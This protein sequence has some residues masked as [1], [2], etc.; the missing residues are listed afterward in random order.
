MHRT[1]I[2]ATLSF[3]QSGDYSHRSCSLFAFILQKET[4]SMSLKGKKIYSILH[5]KCPRC[6]EGELFTN[7]AYSKSFVNMP[8]TCSHCDLR[9]QQEPSF[10]SGAMYVSYALQVALMTTIYVALRV[11]FNPSTETY[12]VTTIVVALVLM[13]V[14]LRLSRAIY[15]NFFYTYKPVP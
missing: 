7:R 4:L 3:H 14:T 15:I 6:H 12:I 13:P 5:H 8:E 1:V 11:L 2:E 9:Y 10:F